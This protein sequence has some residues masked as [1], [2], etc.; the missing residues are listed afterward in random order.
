MRYPKAIQLN[1]DEVCV[2]SSTNV[3]YL[4]MNWD[5]YLN[6]KSYIESITKKV[7]NATGILWKLRQFLPAKTLLNLC[8]A[9]IKPYLRY[10]LI[11]WR[12]TE[13]RTT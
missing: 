4:G 7:A 5:Q 3:Q 10:G 1:I 8:N 9:L 11:I 12:S 13:P 2:K 6:Y